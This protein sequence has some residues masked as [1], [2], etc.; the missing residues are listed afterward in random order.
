VR[1]VDWYSAL[2]VLVCGLHSSGAVLPLQIVLSHRIANHYI[3][4]HFSF[5]L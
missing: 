3:F 1:L 4:A 5:S 2:L